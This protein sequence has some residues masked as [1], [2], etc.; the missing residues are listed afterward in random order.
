MYTL[1]VYLK[2]RETHWYHCFRALF[3][4]GVYLT[5]KRLQKKKKIN[6]YIEDSFEQGIHRGIKM[7]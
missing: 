4:K 7:G 1:G 3:F 6:I 5:L 2:S